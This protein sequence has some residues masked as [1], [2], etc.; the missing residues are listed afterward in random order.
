MLIVM[1]VGF[2]CGAIAFVVFAPAPTGPLVGGIW[3]VMALG[4]VFFS[5]RA[6][7][8]R[9]HDDEI[10]RVGTPATATLV[11]ATTTGML[12]NNVPQWKLQLRIDGA[13]PAYETSLKLCTY[14]PPANGTTLTVRIDPQRRDHVVLADDDTPRAATAATA[15]PAS[16]NGSRTVT[17]MTVDGAGAPDAA[18]TVRLLGELD[19]MHASG[20][21]GDAEFSALKK[22]LLGEG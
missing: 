21:L 22:R 1:G 19:R 15:V 6:L 9:R 11:G 18:E 17:P 12:I 5:L 3:G 14:S 10:R 4:F 20:T 8:G 16:A 2:G 7:A 13:G